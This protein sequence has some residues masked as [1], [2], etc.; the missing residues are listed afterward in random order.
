MTTPSTV[1][2]AGSDIAFWFNAKAKR[3]TPK[4]I[5]AFR[6]ALPHAR[7]L[8]SGSL[9][10]AKREAQTL[11]EKPPRL[12]FCG[13]GDGTVV[14]LLNLLRELGAKSFP[15]IALLQLGTGNG[16]PRATGAPPWRAALKR[17]GKIPL[18]PPTQ[19]FNLVEVEGRLCHFTGVGWD[20]IILHDYRRNLEKR[21][22]Q[23]VA[24]RFATRLHSSVFGYLYS[25]ARITVPEQMALNR[26]HGRATVRVENLGP[27]AYRLDEN[28]Q[29]VELPKGQVVLHEGPHSIAAAATEPFWGGGF[30]AFPYAMAMPGYVN[31]RLYDRPVLEG[32]LNTPRLWRGGIGLPGFHD[33]FLTRGRFVF[34]R[35][36][37]FQV[38]GDVVG[39]R[40]S[41]EL[42]VAKE[43]VQL[44]RWDL[45]D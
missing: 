7:V 44:M 35:E 29:S 42:N 23:L 33:F 16:W 21:R 25:V 38:G 13:G 9:E 19:R 30:R 32:F 14:V 37:P 43:S 6:E 20:G 15:T 18:P 5:A 27:D 2:A 36:V 4:V 26:K 45:V 34:S 8:A 10:D 3:V 22:S 31:V 24:S 39:P 1:L 12:L 11:V 41:L 17:L 28:G 40:D